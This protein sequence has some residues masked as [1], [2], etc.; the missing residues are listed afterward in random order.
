MQIL[1]VQYRHPI[2]TTADSINALLANFIDDRK[3]FVLLIDPLDKNIQLLP[4]IKTPIFQI[5]HFLNVIGRD[6]IMIRKMIP[7]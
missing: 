3:A 5:E 6:F 7:R 4:E 2:Y 1:I